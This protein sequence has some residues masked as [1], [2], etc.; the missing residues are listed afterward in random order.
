MMDDA[1]RAEREQRRHELLE[2]RHERELRRRERRRQRGAGNENPW[3]RLVVG[4]AIL[5]VGVVA[6]LDRLGRIEAND[7]LA[8]WAL[9][10]IGLGL[11]NLPQR[12][13]VAAGVWLAL[14][15]IFLPPVP[16]LPHFRLAE[17][18]GLWPL[19]ISAGGV[20]LIRQA[21]QPVAKDLPGS[22]AFHA[23]AWMGGNVR[24]IGAEDF[25]GGDAVVVM[26]GCEIDLTN[27]H[28]TRE[29]VIDLLAFWGGIEIRVPRN[30]IIEN[31]LNPLLGGVV[32]SAK[33]PKDG[34]GPRL[35]VRGS[36]IM[37]GIEIRNAKEVAA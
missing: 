29:A 2:R 17:L 6:W 35:V 21:L 23:F 19:M 14:G 4:L 5:A 16:F 20:A 36:A 22:S 37:G 7:F 34:D 33:N 30:W 1:R 24:K 10:L 15:F 28:I 32:V 12:R 31:H 18:L 3:T 9:I 26:G 13:W 11:A 25:L 8:W 27:A